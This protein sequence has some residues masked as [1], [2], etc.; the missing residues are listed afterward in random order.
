MRAPS[1]QAPALALTLLSSLTACDSDVSIPSSAFSSPIDFAHACEGDGKTVAPLNDESAASLNQ[2]RMCPDLNGSQGD[3]FG[4]VLDRQ[5]ASL[6]VLQLNPASGDR[7]FIDADYFVPGVTGI[8]VGLGPVR[9]LTAPDWSAF[10]VLS[11]NDQSVD[12]VVIAGFTNDVLAWSKTSFALPGAPTDGAIIGTDLVIVPQ[13]K[14]ELWVYD[15]AASTEAPPLRTIALPDRPLHVELVGAP[16]HYLVTFRDRP[17]VA[18]YKNDGTLLS[19]QGLVPACRN[20][21]DDDG[22]DLVDALDPDCHDRD[23]DDESDATGAARVTRP[24]AAPAFD[25]A[26]PCDDGIDNDGDGQTDFPADLACASADDNGELRPQCDDGIDNDNDGQS[27]L[28]DESCYSPY[29]LSEI[30]NPTEGPFHPTFIDGGDFGRFVYVADERTGEIAVFAWDGTTLSRVS[31][32]ATDATAPVLTSVPFDSFSSEPTETGSVPATR[33]PALHRQGVKNILITE[34]NVSALSAGRLRGELWDRL[35]AAS[36]DA[37]PSVSL[38]PN[39]AEWKP[40]RC[41]PTPTD[42]CVQPALDDATWLAFGPNL[43]GRVQ[44]IEAIRRGTPVHRLAQRTTDLSQRTH[45][46]STPRLSLRGRLINARGEPQVG[47]PFIGGALEEELV[48]RVA[49]ESPARFRRFGVWAPADLETALNEAWSVSFEGIIPQTAGRLGVFS[50]ATTFADPNARFCELGVAAGDW[51]QLTVPVSGTDPE[52]VHA[53]T[54]TLE[55]GRTCPTVAAETAIIEVPIAEVGMSTL[56][57]DTTTLRLRPLRPVLDTDAISAQG[58]PRRACEE[59]LTALDDTLGLPENLRLVTGF[60][61]TKLPA[62]LTYNVR[63]ADWI[64]FGTR[65]GFLHRQRWDRATSTCLIDDTLDSRVV[66]RL[67]EVADATTKYATC[68]PSTDALG[69]A[70][71]DEI[72]D[73][74]TRFFNPSFGLDIFPA[75]TRDGQ[76]T[77]GTIV[78]VPSQQDTVFTFTVTG[79]QTGSALSVSDSLLLMRVPLLDFRRQQVQLDAAARKASI[80]QLRLGDPRVIATFE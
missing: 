7:E 45:D 13:S 24:T 76:T 77:T 52:L 39:S 66:G 9:V 61:T 33:S 25:G 27:D 10:Y 37:S 8:P 18:I 64:V 21:L 32:H 1:L 46:I 57:L 69:F 59:A 63:S 42:T 2:T 73:P 49:D 26:A 56:S 16:D 40:Q 35:I 12:R 11:A 23:D 79:P 65:S 51:L 30:Q 34:T 14:A 74:D 5:P 68:P 3:L 80:L 62:T 20:G 70:A 17:T 19:E 60:A 31:V 48:A 67:S 54:V 71:V 15:L 6:M 47:L 43:D 55:D 72:A 58:I 41:A 38:T 22:D 78:A 75:C 29:Q 50:D 4:V 44:L 28:D 53:V 36:G